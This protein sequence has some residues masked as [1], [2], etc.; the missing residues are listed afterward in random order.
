MDISNIDSIALF[1]SYKCNLNC[2]YCYIS[3]N[4]ETKVIHEDMI[5]FLERDAYIGEI[6]NFY[7]GQTEYLK[8]IELWG[9]EP[10]IGL[11]Y[12]DTH[13]KK[14]FDTFPNLDKI[15]TS[16][17]FTINMD[18]LV[19]FIKTI[20]NSVD[21]PINFLIQ[22]SLDGPEEIVNITRGKN[23]EKTVRDNLRY[24]IEQLNKENLGK[25]TITFTF[26]PTLGID[27]VK[28]LLSDEKYIYN[29]FKYFDDIND[30]FLNL[31][32]NKNVFLNFPIGTSFA[33]P[34]EYTQEDGIL[35]SDFI[36]KL[37]KLTVENEKNH[38]YKY[39]RNFSFN[40][41]SYRISD[42][43]IKYNNNNPINKF[44][45]CGTGERSIAIGPE[46]KVTV[47]HRAFFDSNEI[48]RK[49]AKIKSQ[50]DNRGQEF[51]NADDMLKQSVRST[52]SH[53]TMSD[54]KNYLRNFKILYE[55]GNELAMHNIVSSLYELAQCNQ[56]SEI[57][58]NNDT[59]MFWKTI[60]ACRIINPC[61][62][63]N[64]IINS[65]FYI[66]DFSQLRLWC[67]GAVESTINLIENNPNLYNNCKG[68]CK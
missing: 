1:S 32:I 3:Q 35:F 6:L 61:M 60:Y 47:C 63:D 43:I 4:E 16:S 57:Y 30:E 28:Y 23:I 22:I 49:Q 65:N 41:L 21:R 7:E 18:D 59:D 48:Y 56:I 14:Y 66:K 8:K 55:S 12:F 45:W 13:I 34:G 52:T 68:D 29:Y 10:L 64:A 31:S 51:L 54:Y 67:N 39:Y 2:S 24:V 15:F 38:I 33:G 62:Y 44:G 26:K 40:F 46:G 25:T 36:D 17:N 20:S 9:G 27:S 5:K 37:N 11:K 58:K 50:Q 19:S 42:V 53:I